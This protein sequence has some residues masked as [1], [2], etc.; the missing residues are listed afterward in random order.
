MPDATIKGEYHSSRKDKKEFKE[1]LEDNPDL[2]FIEGRE[3]HSLKSENLTYFLFLIGHLVW[4]NT[5]EK[6]SHEASPVSNKAF[7]DFVL[8]EDP[9]DKLYGN[10]SSIKK[11]IGFVLAYSSSLIGLIVSLSILSIDLRIGAATYGL[12]A[13]LSSL[14]TLFFYFVFLVVLLGVKEREESMISTITK[15]IEKENPENILINCGE[16]HVSY[17]ESKL[18]SKMNVEVK[19]SS[20]K[21]GKL[22]Y[23]TRKKVAEF[24]AVLP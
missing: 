2:V 18:E 17:L 21:I 10:I 14:L 19:H 22:I 8:L 13:I 5:V 4:L 20:N 9:L 3:P 23:R 12:I 24:R 15:Q 1:L 7:E 6:Y 16:L 11:F